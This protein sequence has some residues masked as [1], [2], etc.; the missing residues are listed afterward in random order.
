VTRG[1]LF[2]TSKLWVAAAYPEDVPVALQ[3][4]LD[5]LG[6]PYLDLYLVH[7]PYKLK[8]GAA[9]PA[10]VEDRLPYDPEAY[11]AVWRAM[12]AAVDAGKTRSIGTSN[13]TAK[14]LAALLPHARIRPAVNQV[15]LHP[16]LAQHRLKAWCDA[17]GIVLTAYSPLGSP[18]RPVRLI[19]DTDP[20]PLADPTVTAIAAAHGVSPAVVL[21]RWAVQRG[22]VVIPKSVTPARIADNLQAAA[23]A[24]TD[25]EMA[26]LNGLDAGARIIKGFPWLL[27]GQTWQ[28]LWDEGEYPE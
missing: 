21:I 17:R 2:I 24:L 23:I 12:E 26:A 22:T 20:V 8:K 10:P 9:F 14:K 16:F 27:E 6:T 19:G 18:D 25:A 4:T 11:L 28:S 1:D 7:W 13:M 15:E 3:K 5:D